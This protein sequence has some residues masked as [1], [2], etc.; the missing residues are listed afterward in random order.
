M[1]K[2]KNLT[3]DEEDQVLANDKVLSYQSCLQLVKHPIA[4]EK[5]MDILEKGYHNADEFDLKEIVDIVFPK[6]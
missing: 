2:I 5:V 1:S 4:G 6:Q 3:K